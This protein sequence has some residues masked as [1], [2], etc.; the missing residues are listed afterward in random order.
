MSR[1]LELRQRGHEAGTTGI[2]RCNDPEVLAGL[3]LLGRTPVEALKMLRSFMPIMW[4][5]ARR[6][7]VQA[8]IILMD[9]IDHEE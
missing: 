1:I 5:E 7:A 2:E 9:L 8:E 4:R 3:C 6:A